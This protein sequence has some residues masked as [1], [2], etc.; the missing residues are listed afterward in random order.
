MNHRHAQECRGFLSISAISRPPLGNNWRHAK[1][2]PGK[3][4]MPL[5]WGFGASFAW[6]LL[7]EWGP[8]FLAFDP[9]SDEY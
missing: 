8:R 3:G 9:F 4:N 2:A 5:Y 1:M 7:P 6:M